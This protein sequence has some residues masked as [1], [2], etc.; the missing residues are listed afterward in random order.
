MICAIFP[1]SRISPARIPAIARMIPP[2][3]L[4]STAEGLRGTIGVGYLGMRDLRVDFRT[5]GRQSRHHRTP[6]LHNPV[7]HIIGVLAHDDLL[8]VYEG[9]H[10]I[11]RVLHE[12]D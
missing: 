9:D 5:P 10:G 6:E 3:V 4:L 8:P 12:L 1:P 7:N 2:I 11:G